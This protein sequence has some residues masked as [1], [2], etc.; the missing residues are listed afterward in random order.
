MITFLMVLSIL[1]V[2]FSA[3]VCWQVLE[4]RKVIAQMM[5]NDD[6]ADSEQQPEMVITLRVLD[7]IALAKRE[8]RSAR[9]LADKLP[10]MVRKMVYQEVLKE[11]ENEMAEREIEV[12][13]QLEYR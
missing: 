3:F 11:L 8:S 5:E 4:Q 2:L 9:V 13:M 6:I 12:D 10:V 1:L 7:P